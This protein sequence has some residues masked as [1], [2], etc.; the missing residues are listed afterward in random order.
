MKTEKSQKRTLKIEQRK[1][2]EGTGRRSSEERTTSSGKEQENAESEETAKAE[3]S[4][5]AWQRGFL[6]K[7]QRW[8][9]YTVRITDK[10]VIETQAKAS[11]ENSEITD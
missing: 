3:E 8:K 2:K 10:T 11:G 9:L 7:T 4:M 1:S 5:E 6:S